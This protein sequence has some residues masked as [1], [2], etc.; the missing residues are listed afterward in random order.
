M[1]PLSDGFIHPMDIPLIPIE[2]READRNPDRGPG[3]STMTIGER[4]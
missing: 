4:S 3:A 2:D 1:T